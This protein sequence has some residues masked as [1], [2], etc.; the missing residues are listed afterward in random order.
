MTWLWRAIWVVLVAERLLKHL[1]VVH[2]FYRNRSGPSAD[3]P[4]RVSILQPILSG[5]PALAE[6]LRRNLDAR[7]GYEREFLWLIDADDAE[8]RRI[9]DE[10][11]VSRPDAAVRL[12]AVPPPPPAHNPKLVKL[13]VGASLARGA[14]LCVLDDDTVIPDGGLERCLPHLDQPGVGLA[15][16]LP[17]YTSFDTFWSSLVA[18]FVN[19]SSLMTYIP[20]ATL[21]DPV[22]I[23]GMFYALRRETLDAVGGFAGLESFVA[24]DFAVADR[25][26]AHGYRLAQTPLLHP[27]RT[28]VR[29]PRHYFGL[30]QRWLIFPRESLMRHLKPGELALFYGLA[31]APIFFPWLAAAA[32]LLRAGPGARRFALAYFA[33]SLGIF[34]HHNRAYLGGATPPRALVLV[35]LVQLAL[36]AQLLAALLAPRRINWRGHVLRIERGGRLRLVRRR[37]P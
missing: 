5:D 1:A 31:A 27:I 14:I 15:F 8:A 13:V 6:C 37:E 33:L 20:F 18:C 4:E 7:S 10:L 34:A 25:L 19:S 36:P 16:G 28:T 23:N 30:L 35:P 9:C 17:F 11:V 2:F 29:G 12:I 3:S 26:R 21:H 24:D 32:P 22:T